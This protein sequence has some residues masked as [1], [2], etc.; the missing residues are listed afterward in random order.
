MAMHR[1]IPPQILAKI[2]IVYS[3][4]KLFKAQAFYWT[5]TFY[6]GQN[7]NHNK[8]A[9]QKQHFGMTEPKPPVAEKAKAK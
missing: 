3:N 2:S 9:V 5:D 1:G 6:I 7:K 8:G 4:I